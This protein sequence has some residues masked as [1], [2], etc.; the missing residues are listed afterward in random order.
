MEVIDSNVNLEN[1]QASL[2]SMFDKSMRPKV[3]L[4]VMILN[5]NDEVLVSQRK[6]PGQ[7]GDGLWCFPGGHLEFGESFQECAHREVE[8][9]AAAT[10]NFESIKYLTTVNAFDRPTG[11]HYIVIYMFTKVLK[12]QHEF[13]NMEPNKQTDWQWI[14]WNEF[15]KFEN[16]FQPYKFFFKQGFND[17]ANIKRAVSD[18]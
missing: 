6:T 4:G 11:Y 18:L 13:K 8:E 3:G 14:K 9:E 16:L 17:L 7:A 2:A 12:D 1:Q 15:V 5:E 10:L